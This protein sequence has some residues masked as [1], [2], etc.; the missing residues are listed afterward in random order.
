MTVKTYAPFVQNLIITL[1]QH[2]LTEKDLTLLQEGYLT[3]ATVSDQLS[4]ARRLK[5]L[6]LIIRL[7]TEVK[8]L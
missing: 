2:R 8:E 1:H 6:S 4:L 3:E 7:S 5:L